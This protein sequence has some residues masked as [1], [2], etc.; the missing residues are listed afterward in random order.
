MNSTVKG[1]I[2]GIVAAV[3]YGM[4]P[5]FTLPLYNQ[6]MTVDSVLFYRYAFAVLILGLIMKLQ[7]RS[8]AI[9]KNEIFPLA[10]VG[11]LFS[12]SSLFLYQSFLYM[13]AG[14]A[15]TILFVYPIMVAVIMF[16]FFHEKAS[17]LTTSCIAMA[18]TGISLLYKS[19][20]GESLNFTGMILVILSSLSYAIYMIG[21]N[22][23]SLRRMSTAKLTFYGLLFGLFVY[24]VRLQ[25][26]TELQPIP[27]ANAWINVLA[28]A[29]FPT[30][31]SLICIASA[32]HRIGSTPTA[33]LGALEPVTALVLG[34]M[35]F[36]EKI[37]PRIV[38]GVLLILVAVSLMVVG[39]PLARKGKQMWVNLKNRKYFRANG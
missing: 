12:G 8:L 9:K 36:N 27:S 6:G 20:G 26:L 22:Q 30:V 29:F 14:I 5:L 24:I 32:I 25:F 16:L 23:S 15:C 11:L 38:S 13:D 3:S 7:K 34:V 19:E 18:L 33:I 35:I 4:N 39:K 21:V 28:L 37:T 17:W 2:Y 10:L 31:V 1:I